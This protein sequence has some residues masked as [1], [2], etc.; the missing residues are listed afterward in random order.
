MKAVSWR[1]FMT[2][3]APPSGNGA[4]EGGGRARAAREHERALDGG[5][6]VLGLFARRVAPGFGEKAA[7]APC[8]RANA[9]AISSRTGS[10]ASDAA[11]AASRQPSRPPA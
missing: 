11:K 4:A 10:G 8:R 9:A 2:A 3:A 5:D 6:A 1:R 7:R